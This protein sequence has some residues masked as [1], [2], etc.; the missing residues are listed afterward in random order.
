M[1]KVDRRY[2]IN[3]LKYGAIYYAQQGYP[4][5]CVLGCLIGDLCY[6]YRTKTVPYTLQGH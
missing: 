1:R 5:F 4:V 3:T 6:A 2:F